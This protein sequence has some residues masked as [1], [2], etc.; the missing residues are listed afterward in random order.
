[1]KKFTLYQIKKQHTRVFDHLGRWDPKAEMIDLWY[2]G[3]LINE[4][5]QHSEVSCLDGF[6]G[7]VKGN[8]SAT[9]IQK[10]YR[11]FASRVMHTR[12]RHEHL[13][14]EKTVA[15]SQVFEMEEK[16]AA[17]KDV[18][19]GSPSHRAWVNAG[20][21][22][23]DAILIHVLAPDMQ[24]RFPG[25]D[26]PPSGNYFKGIPKRYLVGDYESHEEELQVRQASEA[27]SAQVQRELSREAIAASGV[28]QMLRRRQ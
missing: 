28:R 26:P 19:F 15:Q 22:R 1:M 23:E 27:Y 18:P 16:L 20:L 17:E 6:F 14:V 9:K 5:V 2:F 13:K 4:L 10:R 24:G 7:T 25:D 8:E 11:G 21:V 12:S 3:K